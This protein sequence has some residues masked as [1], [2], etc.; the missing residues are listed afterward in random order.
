MSTGGTGEPSRFDD[1]ADQGKGPAGYFRGA[2]FPKLLVLVAMV[3][4]GTVIVAGVMAARVWAAHN[5][6]DACETLLQHLNQRAPSA[7]AI[8]AASG[9]LDFSPP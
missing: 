7:P 3:M 4:T 2:E 5:A 6:Q 8:S 9:Y 1:F